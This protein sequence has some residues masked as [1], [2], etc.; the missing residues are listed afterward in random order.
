MPP[1][2]RHAAPPY[3]RKHANVKYVELGE[4]LAKALQLYRAH[5]A[6]AA[7]RLAWNQQTNTCCAQG[8]AF[9]GHIGGIAHQYAAAKFAVT[10]APSTPSCSAALPAMLALMG[11]CARCTVVNGLKATQVAQTGILTVFV[12][13]TACCARSRPL[14]R[15]MKPTLRRRWR[16]HA[17]SSSS[18]GCMTE[19]PHVSGGERARTAHV[20]A[21]LRGNVQ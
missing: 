16:A 1:L 12:R 9:A 6:P 19:I 2:F 18:V 20:R 3:Y 13:P 14:P 15:T 17:V 8:T 10:A 7:C 11:S 21:G 5:G 4:W